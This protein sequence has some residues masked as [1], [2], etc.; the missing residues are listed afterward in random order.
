MEENSLEVLEIYIDYDRLK[1][2]D[3][4]RLLSNLSFISNRIA[5]DY[6]SR[7]KDYADEGLPTLDIETVNTGGSIKFKLV[8]GWKMSVTSGKGKEADIVVS[9][10]KKL[11]IPIVIGYLIVSMANG[12][13]DFRNKQLDNRLKAL[14]IQ[15]KETELSKAMALNKEEGEQ[16]TFRLVLN[17]VDDKVPEV[18]PVIMD[19]VKSVLRN[20]DFAKFR[21]NGIEIKNLEGQ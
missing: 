14:E 15:L 13:Q 16:N 17:Y 3:L 21:V 6:F 4:A 19:T 18:K 8:E 5:E 12:Y 10:P 9:I 2:A 20:P 1:A 7:F 11:G